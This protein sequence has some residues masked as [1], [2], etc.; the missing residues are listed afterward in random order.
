MFLQMLRNFLEQ[1]APLNEIEWN[2]FL[3]RIAQNEFAKGDII[4]SIN[5]K[6][7]Q[8]HFIVEGVARHYFF[9]NG[10]NEIT[11]WISEIG[12][13]STDYAAFTLHAKTV[14]QIQAVTPVKT[15]SISSTKLNELYDI[16]KVWERI[17]RLMNQKYLNDFIERNNFLIMLNAKERYTSLVAAKPHLFNIVPLRH[18]A[19]YLNISVETLS[20][21][22]SNSY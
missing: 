16:H 22:R 1:Y 18:L 14:Y 21:L 8:L 19:T 9:D 11:I 4:E 5:E 13:L 12:G 2:D 6:V 3:E 20:R 15:I 17:G 10:N 7:N